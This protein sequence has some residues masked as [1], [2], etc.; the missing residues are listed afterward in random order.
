LPLTPPE[1]TEWGNP[2]TDKAAFNYMMAYSPYDQ[3]GTKAYPPILA[4]TALSDSQV[5]YWEPTKWVAKL[6]EKSPD[7][8]PFL[9]HVNLEAGH[10]GASGRFDRL[11]EVAESHAFALWC[12]GKA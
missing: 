11:K 6:R 5:T 8:G 4:Q 12:L 9:L 2:I 1:W 3:V 10:G 7:A